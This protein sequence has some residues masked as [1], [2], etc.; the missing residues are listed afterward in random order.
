[1]SAGGGAVEL[2]VGSSIRTAAYP[3]RPPDPTRIG[4]V[5]CS[6]AA[7]RESCRTTSPR[8]GDGSR[9]TTSRCLVD[10]LS[11]CIVE[12]AQTV[13]FKGLVGWG[14]RGAVLHWC[15][16]LQGQYQPLVV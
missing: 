4:A 12:L 6:P 14:G 2:G 15:N 11:Q 9:R 1:M 13:R 7:G 10:R 8:H 5:F 16:L 3:K